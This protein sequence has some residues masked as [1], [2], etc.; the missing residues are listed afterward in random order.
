MVTL[1]CHKRQGL[2]LLGKVIHIYDPVLE[3]YLSLL[4]KEVMSVSPEGKNFSNLSPSEQLSL[5]Q[6]KSDRNIVIKEADKG[7]AVV[8]WD[9]GTT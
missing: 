7:S 1:A 4:E 6:L 5:K 3:N 8:V 2:K 9:R